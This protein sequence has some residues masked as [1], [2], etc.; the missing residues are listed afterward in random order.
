[1]ELIDNSAEDIFSPTAS[2][3]LNGL[4]NHANSSKAADL[5]YQAPKKTTEEKPEKP[6]K[7]KTTTTPPTKGSEIIRAFL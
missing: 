1:M 2:N 4:F 3:G 5:K 7:P 6:E